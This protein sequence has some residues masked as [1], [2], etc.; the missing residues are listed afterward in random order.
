M[1][2]DNL[3]FK[4]GIHAPDCKELT[5]HKAIEKAS[6]PKVVYIPLHQHVGAPCEALVNVGDKVKVGQKIGDSKAFVSSP[7]HSSVSGVV[8]GITP[9]YTVSGTKT[10]CVVIESDGLNEIHES[11]KPRA[12]LEKLSKDEIQDVIREAGIVGMGGAAFPNHAKLLSSLDAKI[13]SAILNGAECEPYLTCDHRLMLEMPELVIFGL[14]TMIKY[15]DVEN[16]YIGVEDNKMDAI[17]ALRGAVNKEDKINVV[18]LKTK[19]PQGDST[20]MVDSILDRVVPIGGRC[21]DASS[22]VTNVGTSVAIAEAVLKGKP[23]FERVIT[24]TGNG[25]KE[26]KNLLVKVGTTIREVIEQCGGFKGKPG[27]VIAGG[28]MTGI[29][30]FSLDVPIVKSTCGILVLTEEESMPDKVSPCVKCGKCV[31]VC[32][33]RLQPLYISGYA[34]KN[35]FE[36]AEKYSALECIEC[37][38]CSFIC[39]SKRPLTESI[40]HAKRQINSKRKKS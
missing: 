27:K 30:Q 2:L 7:V 23:L 34:L 13:D 35:N 10:N 28:P 8:K 12:D 14:K 33:V 38:A 1:K 3:T 21:K 31:E 37:G 17:E 18:S 36:M 6:E 19:F 40:V 32:S 9:M 25:I 29:A 15:L 22:I 4:G 11:V 24:V 20:R 26:P 16:S 39:P 5:K